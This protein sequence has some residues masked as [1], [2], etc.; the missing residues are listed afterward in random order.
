MPLSA[1]L[2]PDATPGGKH[3]ACPKPVQAAYSLFHPARSAQISAVACLGR[4]IKHT[5]SHTGVAMVFHPLFNG[6]S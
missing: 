5:H 3:A 6:E 4:Q 1:G 2:L